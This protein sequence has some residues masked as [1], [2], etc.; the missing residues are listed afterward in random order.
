M[1]LAIVGGYLNGLLDINLSY[2]FAIAGLLQLLFVFIFSLE[3]ISIKKN[4]LFFVL[5]LLIFV[6]FSI[7]VTS[8]YYSNFYIDPLIKEKII[9]GAWPHRD[10]VFNASI[11]GMI[12]T[13]GSI[14]I[15]LDGINVPVYYHIFSH[16]I[17]GSLSALLGISTMTFYALICPIIIIPFFFLSFIY[18]TIFFP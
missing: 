14:S 7:W 12:K 10:S 4:L 2:F 3:E 11:A 18:C 9:N 1:I 8:A 15:G 5:T 6:L 17:F 13:Y 16:Y